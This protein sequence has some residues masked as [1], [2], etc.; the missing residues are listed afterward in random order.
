VSLACANGL[1]QLFTGLTAQPFDAAE[2]RVQCQSCDQPQILFGQGALCGTATDPT[3]CQSQVAAAGDR[4][5]LLFQ[6][7]MPMY[8]MTARYVMT[9][10]GNEVHKYQ[11]REEL[12]QFLGP[13]DSPQDALMLLYYDMRGVLCGAVDRTQS[14]EGVDPATLVELDDGYQAILL[15]QMNECGNVTTTRVTLHIARDGA[16]A[17]TARE[18]MLPQT[19]GCP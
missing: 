8:G 18:T 10:L 5:T 19:T 16:V 2:F 7:Y 9:S 17:E 15:S 1:P 11:T 14:L 4:A 3:A 6:D 12:L 13:I